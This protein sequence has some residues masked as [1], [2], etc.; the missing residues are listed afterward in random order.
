MSDVQ[1]TPTLTMFLVLHDA[2]AAVMNFVCIRG[3]GLVRTLEVSWFSSLSSDD[4]V[5]PSVC[6]RPPSTKSLSN[7]HSC[8]IYLLVVHHISAEVEISSLHD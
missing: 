4:F 2:V 7:H 6:L 8:S 1:H 5:E 3:G